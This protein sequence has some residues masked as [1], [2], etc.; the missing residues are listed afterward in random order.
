MSAVLDKA[1]ARLTGK[2]KEAAEG[3]DNKQPMSMDQ[4]G[5]WYMQQ[6]LDFEKS[7]TEESR[8]SKKV[9]WRVATGAMVLAGVAIIAAGANMFLTSPT[10]L[11][12]GATT[13][14]PAKSRS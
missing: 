2:G 8:A 10:R 9:A 12:C 13:A 7:K 3:G 5:E 1:R 14:S 11:A 4:L 6:A